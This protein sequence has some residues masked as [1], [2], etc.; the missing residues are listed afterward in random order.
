MFQNKL[1]NL[2]NISLILE[3]K[4]LLKLCLSIFLTI[5]LVGL[6]ILSLAM[7]MPLMDLIL[8]QNFENKFLFNFMQRFN[9]HQMYDLFIQYQVSIT[10]C[11]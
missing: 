1:S 5:C 11:V 2:E 8:N 9:F 3:K 10:P 7:I 4:N 6:E